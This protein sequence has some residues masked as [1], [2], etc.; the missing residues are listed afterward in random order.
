MGGLLY[1]LCVYV[2]TFL[3]KLVQPRRGAYVCVLLQM[4]LVPLPSVG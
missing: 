2:F 1:G 4:C 3:P